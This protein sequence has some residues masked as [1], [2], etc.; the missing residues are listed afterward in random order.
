MPFYENKELAPYYPLHRYYKNWYWYTY[1][2]DKKEGKVT[3]VRPEPA[4]YF[5]Y[6]DLN[7]L[8]AV[9][10]V[11]SVKRYPALD[12]RFLFEDD[13]TNAIGTTVDANGNQ[14]EGYTLRV[15]RP[16]VSDNRFTLVG[17]PFMCP[18][19]YERLFNANKKNN[20]RPGLY[21]YADGAWRLASKRGSTMRAKR[22]KEFDAIA[23]LQAFVIF[24]KS[25]NPNQT[26][27]F[28][29]APAE[30][31][32]LRDPNTS[33]FELRSTDEELEELEELSERYVAVT[34]TDERGGYASAELLPENREESMPALFASESMQTA[35]LVYFISPTDSSCNFVQTNVP[36]AV[37]EL[38]VFAPA[39][40]MLTLDF[41]TLAEKP[42][43]K[44]ALYDRLRGTEQDLLA[45]PTYSYGYSERDGRRFELRMSYGNVRYEEQQD[46][47]ADLAIERTA[48]GYRI[49]YDQGIAGYQLYS[50]H[51][52]LL[53]RATTDGQTQVDIEMPETDVVLL[54]VQ[55]A[56]GLRWIK[57]LQ[58]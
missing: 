54:D 34:V 20:L 32:V 18:I 12:Y 3:A 2:E 26:L 44:L 46:H 52:Y 4:S 43:D 21:I 40:G 15:S 24:L 55:S 13:K 47:Q 48:T 6:F 33:K 49:S 19:D 51:G 57:K 58:R 7:T 10:K 30:I 41:T 5:A 27:Y 23:P 50:V 8:K 36:S 28:P 11:D 31:S 53:E 38:G 37:V 29:T 42:F 25:E 1:D 35:P 16:A 9:C 45:N 39:D 22:D 14:V 56:D 17:N